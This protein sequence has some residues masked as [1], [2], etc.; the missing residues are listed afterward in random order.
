MHIALIQ[1]ILTSIITVVFSLTTLSQ[2]HINQKDKK[3]KKQGYWVYKGVDHPE[4][5]YCDSCIIESGNYIDDRKEGFWIKYYQNGN[6][7][8][9][10]H[11]NNSRPNGSFVKYYEN[12]TLK[13]SGSFSNKTKKY[14]GLLLTYH[15]NGR[16]ESSRHFSNIGTEYDTSRYYGKNGIIQ[17][18]Y[19]ED[20][21]NDSYI[22]ISYF[23]DG[24]IKDTLRISAEQRRESTSK[25]PPNK[26]CPNHPDSEHKEFLIKEE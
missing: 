4:K 19:I 15:P 17:W 7:Q 21:I 26:K 6:I 10:G 25:K 18:T 22:E 13:T 23:K 12:G 9:I 1:Y 24:C 16:L 20:T 3:G 11:W 8:L 2:S 5:G 14:Y